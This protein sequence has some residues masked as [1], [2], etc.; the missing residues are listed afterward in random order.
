MTQEGAADVLGVSIK[1]VQRRLNR[2]LPLLA[3]KLR[4]LQ[5][6]IPAHD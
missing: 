4:D 6:D 2:T 5:P 3:M 1:T